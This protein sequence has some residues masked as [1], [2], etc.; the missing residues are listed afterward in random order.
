MAN[1]LCEASLFLL[2]LFVCLQEIII[3]VVGDN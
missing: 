2:L 3:I 1:V